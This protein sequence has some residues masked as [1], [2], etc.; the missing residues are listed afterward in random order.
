MILI[1]EKKLY[2]FWMPRITAGNEASA[3]ERRFTYKKHKK[4]KKKKSMQTTTLLL[5]F[6]ESGDLVN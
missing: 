6:R 1:L 2:L 3:D 5:R 4:K